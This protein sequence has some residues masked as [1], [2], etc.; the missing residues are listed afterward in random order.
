MSTSFAGWAGLLAVRCFRPNLVRTCVRALGQPEDRGGGGHAAARVP[1]PCR[2]AALRRPG[3]ARRA[4]LRGPLEVGAQPRAGGVG[5]AVPVDDQPVPRLHARLRVLLRPSDPHLPGHGR[6]AG[7]RARDRREGQRA[8]GPAARAG[9]AVVVGRARRDGDEH[10]PL[11]VGR[12]QVPADAGDL[13][14]AAR[15]GQPVLGAD[16]VAARAA[17][18]RAAAGDRGVTSISANLSVPTLEPKAWRATEPHTPHPRARLEAV[19]ELNR[20]GIPT[21]VLV[22]R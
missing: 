16:Q 13:G 4:L 1:R 11:S 5:D 3:G 6:G 15:R 8:G 21:G 22:R 2:R 12:V 7:L 19:A 14:G 17:R 9:A 18:R 20:A 10:R